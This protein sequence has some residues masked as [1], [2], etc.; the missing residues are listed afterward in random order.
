MSLFD[1]NRIVLTFAAL[2]D[3]HNSPN[4]PKALRYLQSVA[5]LDAIVHCGDMTDGV[6]YYN[7]LGEVEK[8]RRVYEAE[9]PEELRWFYCLGN[10]DSN[11]GNRAALFYDNMGERFYR[12]DLT[13]GAFTRETACRHAVIGGVHF[14]AVESHH[15]PTRYDEGIL[16]WLADTLAAA[17]ADA[18]G[19]PIFVLTHDPIKDTVHGSCCDG[20]ADLT[21]VL[22]KY[23]QVVA[24]TGH[25]HWPLYHD[26]SIHQ[27]EFTSVNLGS[28]NFM[29]APKDYIEKHPPFYL[30]YNAYDTSLGT[31]MEVDATGA[32]R[33]TRHNFML[34][35]PIRE[36]WIIPAPSA[37][38]THLTVYPTNYGVGAPAP[39]FLQGD[40][41]TEITYARTLTVRHPAAR[42]QGMVFSYRYDVVK[43]DETVKS[44]R[45]IS[46]FWNYT[47]DAELP[48]NC[49]VT[50]EE[51]PVEP[52]FAVRITALDDWDNESDPLEVEV[53]P[54]S[55]ADIATAG[56]L[57]AHFANATAETVQPLWEAF[58][59]LP[60]RCRA[61]VNRAPLDAALAVLDD[62]VVYEETRRYAP[63]AV[64]VDDGVTATAAENGLHLAFSGAAQGAMAVLGGV[65]DAEALHLRLRVR[66]AGVLTLL[67]DSDREAP[68]FD[69][70]S[71]NLHFD[72]ATGLVT[73]QPWPPVHTLKTDLLIR[74]AQTGAPVDVHLFRDRDDGYYRLQIVTDE[75]KAAG[76]VVSS[77]FKYAAYMSDAQHVRVALAAGGKEST[78]LQVQVMS[79]H[80][81]EVPCIYEARFDVR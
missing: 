42:S 46:G 59:A 12:G 79:L 25:S 53:Q 75:G 43:D 39:V 28:V 49:C 35:R 63:T 40:V 68:A 57:S 33:I 52:P 62:T 34:Q 56:A 44:Y 20:C 1:E 71:T 73:A 2:T 60:Y 5:K 77:A 16:A 26:G 69:M 23:P 70:G 19:M 29:D 6:V 18:P 3:L 32:V 22:A 14:I 11:G 80:G 36:P 72:F 47:T 10:H 15:A 74:A 76:T 48:T 4:V 38:G 30:L 51:L 81:G 24:L 41:S 37:D 17:A 27:R 45:S 8:V 31:V 7:N 78:D 58:C 50:L 13:D 55:F 64:R 21:P 65:Y 9:T 67:L 66:G 61:Q 54:A